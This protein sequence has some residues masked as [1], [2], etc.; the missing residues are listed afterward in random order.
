MNK[1]LIVC[2]SIFTFNFAHAGL[3]IEPYAGMHFNSGIDI[4]GVD[5]DI[6]GASVGARVGYTMLGFM[7]GINYKTGTLEFDYTD[8][9]GGKED[10]T[11]SHYG[12]F[13]GYSFPILLRVWGELVIGGS[14]DVEDAGTFEEV[15]GTQFGIGYSLLPLVS[16]NFEI[17]N[18]EIDDYDRSGDPQGDIDTFF[19]SISIPFNI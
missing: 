13:V 5:G 4:E 3:L 17:G 6:S 7:T 8:D 10:Y 19:L 14:A 11:L 16:L 2:L 18:L 9:G 12:V 1:F 15:S